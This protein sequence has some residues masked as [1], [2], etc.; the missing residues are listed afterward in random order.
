MSRPYTP[1]TKPL[2][3]SALVS[4][5]PSAQHQ[6]SEAQPTHESDS[7]SLPGPQPSRAVED[8]VLPETSALG[9]NLTWGSCF[10]LVISRVIGSGIFATPGTII[11]EV[12]SP[13]LSIVL[14]LVGGVVASCSLAVSLEYGSMLP[15]SGGE[16]VY[17]EFTYRRPRFLASVVIAVYVVLLGLTVSNCIIFSQYVLFAFGREEAQ[18]A[19][20]KGLAAGLLI[21]ITS[22]HVLFPSAGVRTQNFFGWLK[23]G[24][25]GL[26]VLCGLYVVLLRKD[27]LQNAAIHRPLSWDSL[28]EDSVWSWSAISTALFKVFYSYAGLDNMVNVLN[29]VKNP[30]RTLKTVS[31]T[32]LVTACAMYLLVNIAYLSVVPLDEIK[33]SGELIAALFFEKVFGPQLGRKVLPLAV[34]LSAAGNVMVVS[35]ALVRSELN[36]LGLTRH[37]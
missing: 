14:W 16:K 13:G 12:G 32:A 33:Q 4:G 21:A 24:M 11:R 10:I 3:G 37:C 15:R 26:M 27:Q 8:D 6:R 1:E 17:F 36:R 29:E 22:I 2:L 35:F 23:M 30:V 7:E 25:A 20:R 28:W 9:R 34:A 19:E 5:T 31:I 18:A